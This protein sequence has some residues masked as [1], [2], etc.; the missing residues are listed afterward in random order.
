MGEKRRHRCS[1]HGTHP[2]PLSHDAAAVEDLPAYALP[3][4]PLCLRAAGGMHRKRV[5][6][7]E[8]GHA[9]N[10]GDMINKMVAKMGC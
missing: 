2:H 1:G 10:R 9:G 7:I 6:Y 8:G 4:P 5:H 3:H